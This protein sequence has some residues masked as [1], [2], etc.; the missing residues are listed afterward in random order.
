MIENRSIRD[1]E[2][3]SGHNALSRRATIRLR[4][5]FTLSGG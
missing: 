3:N 1:S 2:E 5:S 4:L